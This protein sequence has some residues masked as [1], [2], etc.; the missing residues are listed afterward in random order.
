MNVVNN[1]ELPIV[2]NVNFGHATPR[3]DLQYG[4]MVK[5]NMKKKKIYWNNQETLLWQYHIK[6]HGNY[7]LTKK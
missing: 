3:C 6:D 2:Y 7:Q 1:P 5:V 4:V